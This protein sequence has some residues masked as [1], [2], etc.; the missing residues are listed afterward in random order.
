MSPP[1][2]I[3]ISSQY[4]CI[5]YEGPNELVEGRAFR[6]WATL[7]AA[8]YGGSSKQLRISDF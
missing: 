3:R 1:A 6:L 7:I 4:S 5:I 2:A 8:F